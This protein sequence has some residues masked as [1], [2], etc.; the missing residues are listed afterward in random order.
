MGIAPIAA[1]PIIDFLS[2]TGAV[3]PPYELDAALLASDAYVIEYR[4]SNGNSTDAP[5]DWPKSKRDLEIFGEIEAKTID[6]MMR[7]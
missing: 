3:V 7:E 4:R 5:F 6:S 2:A 1:G